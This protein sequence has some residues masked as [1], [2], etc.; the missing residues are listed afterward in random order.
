MMG[1]SDMEMEGKEQ[2]AAEAINN[3]EFACIESVI[4]GGFQNT[5]DLQV[6]NYDEDMATK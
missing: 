3:E 1:T 2:A 5:K 6:M 4:G